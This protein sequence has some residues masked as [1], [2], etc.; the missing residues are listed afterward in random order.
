MH[1]SKEVKP[2]WERLNITRILNVG[3]SPEF[4]PIESV[5]SQ[6]KRDFCRQRLNALVNNAEFAATT[7]IKK[8]FKRLKQPAIAACVRRSRFLLSK[9]I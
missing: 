5:F 8:A 7:Y 2:H 1:K 3:Y 6:V 4:N 9:N